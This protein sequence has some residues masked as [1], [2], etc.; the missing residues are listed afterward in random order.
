M[1]KLHA[2][3]VLLYLTSALH[4][5]D[6]DTLW[7]RSLERYRIQDYHGM[8]SNLDTLINTVP[9]FAEGYY[10]R[11]LAWLSLGNT[12]EACTD[13][14][15]ALK[16]GEN[17][18]KDFIAYE[19]D[20]S[21][22]RDLLLQQFYKDTKVEPDLGF[23]PRYTRADT[24]RGSL[25]YER[26]CFDVSFYDL[27]LRINLARKRI[28]AGNSI[29]FTII[30]PTRRIQLDLFDNLVIT[31]ITWNGRSL[32]WQREFNAVFIDFPNELKTGE[33]HN[34][35]IAYKGKPV[36]APNPPWDGG[37]VWKKDKNGN[38][39]IGVACEQLGA[40]SWWPTKDHLSDKPDSMQIQIEIPSGYSAV[41]NGDLKKVTPLGKKLTRFTWFVEYPINNYNATFY[42]GKYVSFNDTLV[43]G[44]DT[45]KLDY[46]VLE[47]NLDT[48]KQ[49]FKQVG[50]VLRFYNK[51]FGFFPF[52]KDGFGLVE[53][54]YEGME[55]QTAIAYGHG[56]SENNARDYKNR[57]YDYIIVHEAAH[58]WWGNSVTAADMADV[59]IHEGFAT[60]AEYMFLEDRLGIE[61]SMSELVSNS[62]YIFNVWPMVQ[63]RDVNED[64]F[65]G[66]DVYNKGAMMLHCLRCA[67][68]DDSLFFSMIRD[69]CIRYKYTT[70]NSDDFILFVNKTTG[71]DYS[72]FFK[73]FL[74]DT[75]IPVLEYRYE[76]GKNATFIEYR[77]AE[78]DEGFNMPFGI[79]LGNGQSLRLEGTTSWNKT[80]IEGVDWFNFYNLMQGF[81]G[82]PHNAF[83][84]Y[85]TRY[86]K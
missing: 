83:T 11:G 55:H 21:F 3:F 10:N 48:A 43:E 82:C 61:E 66:N 17:I 69:F 9:D 40:S 5:Q 29:Y 50:D 35:H 34:I 67:I 72:A 36:I 54:P 33:F 25:R 73:K 65:A 71:S 81:E 13:L 64:A 18:N 26:T 80:T 51:A 47:Y 75:K 7:N 76:I 28:T 32:T 45:L 49:H 60:Y 68:N 63:N 52:A 46:H 59:W 12:V 42:I 31:A 39:W 53:S 20:P 27:T 44:G 79:K 84:Y 24:L 8:I 74:Y 58:E 23:R 2:V 4:S 78:A 70:V 56:Y 6:F 62:R 14:Q 19:C 15:T 37:F 30:Q 57:L 16:L 41:S 1:K 85:Q 38:H 22:T 86:V 77:W